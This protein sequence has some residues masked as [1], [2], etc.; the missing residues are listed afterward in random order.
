MMARRP[1][2]QL[3][4]SD[5]QFSIG[6]N[7]RGLSNFRTGPQQQASN[8]HDKLFSDGQLTQMRAAHNLMLCVDDLKVRARSRLP[9]FVYDF[10]EGGAEDERCYARN[11]AD[12]AALQLVP[13]CLRDTT[14]VD[15]GA[16]VFGQAWRMPVGIAPV[17]LAGLI[18]PGADLMLARAAAAEGVPFV[19]STASN[20]RIESVRAAAPNGMLWMQLYVM[21]DRAIAEQIVRRARIENY[22]A[23]VLTVDVPVNGYRQRDL[24]NGFKLPFRLGAGM[25]AD[26]V[27]HP[28]WTL[29]MARGGQPHFV[30]LSEDARSPASAQAQAG[31]LARAMDRRL[32]WDAIAWLRRLW[33]GPLLVKG[34]LHPDDALLAITHGVDGLLVSNHGGRQLDVAPSSIAALR[35]ILVAVEDRIPV[36]VDSGFRRG[37]DVAKAIAMGA[38]A[39]LVGR[40]ALWGVAAAGESGARLALQMLHSELER[41]MILLGCGSMDDLV[42]AHVL[43][44]GGTPRGAPD[45]GLSAV[46]QSPCM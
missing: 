27:A 35:R 40:A 8:S 45:S 31:L 10:V 6:A 37:S 23:L 36:I 9:R 13:H 19:L 44:A 39:V 14:A 24:R 4:R 12:L 18:R 32:T 42:Q 16:Q 5:P 15:T 43:Q 22:A 21:S 30:N 3:L 2:R 1:H 28:S 41:T 25:L 38:R 17:G 7:A 33:T 26:M 11:L 20:E 34:V 46:D 29:A